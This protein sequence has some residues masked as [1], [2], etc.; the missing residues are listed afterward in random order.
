MNEATEAEWGFLRSP[1]WIV[2][3]VAVLA[4]VLAMIAAGLWQINRHG[5]RADRNDLVRARSELAAVD[6]ATVAPAGADASI[7]D[8]EQFRRVSAT[9]EFRLEDEVLIRNRTF[10]GA[11]GWWVLTPFI[12]EDGSA[13]AVNRGWIPAGFSAEEARPETAPPS[14]MVTI[15][16]FVQPA[17]QAEGFQVADPADGVLSSLARPDVERL[18]QQLDYPL[19][20]V[21]FQL[22]PDGFGE[23]SGDELPFTLGLPELDAGPHASYAAQWF[24]FTTIALVGYPL[25][26]RRVSRG[27]A[28]SLPE[29]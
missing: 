2:S 24:I 4:L 1:K 16:G 5:E 19:S 27:Q 6:I 12:L 10:D 18:A 11:P 23:R 14:G 8:S 29:D 20:P 17:R 3:H 15:V 26:L 9:G 25:I 7:G 21:V 28:A 13:V 22:A